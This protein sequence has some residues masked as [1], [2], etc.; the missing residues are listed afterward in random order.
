MH[1]DFA[2]SF[3]DSDL[4][5]PKVQGDDDVPSDPARERTVLFRMLRRS[6]AVHEGRADGQIVPPPPL[7]LPEGSNEE[8]G[9]ET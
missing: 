3:D 8:T 1:G 6:R 7:G 2:F 9:K 5:F 4:E